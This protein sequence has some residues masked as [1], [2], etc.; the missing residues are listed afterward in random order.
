MLNSLEEQRAKFPLVG[1]WSALK[2]H[3]AD[4]GGGHM[5]RLHI[6]SGSRGRK[7]GKGRG[8]GRHRWS[9]GVRGG[10]GS[11]KRGG[12]GKRDSER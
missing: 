11:D 1:K 12:A 9:G 5:L 3:E 2:E 10:G 8:M 4:G 7:K 6:V